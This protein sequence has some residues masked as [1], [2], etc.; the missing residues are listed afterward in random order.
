MLIYEHL[1]YNNDNQEN[2]SDD[3]LDIQFALYGVESE[4]FIK[5]A[6]FWLEKKK[7][8]KHWLKLY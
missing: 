5:F 1:Q 7:N 2:Y 8:S 6:E 3:N 4:K